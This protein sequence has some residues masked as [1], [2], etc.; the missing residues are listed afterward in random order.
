MLV[1]QFTHNDRT[2]EIHT[3][4]DAVNPRKDFDH[5]G[6]I[7]YNSSRYVLGDEEADTEEIEEITKSNAIW[8]PV[9]AYIH[10]GV[11][12]NTT[13][14]HCPWDSGQCGIIYV[15]REDALREYGRKR[16]SKKLVEQVENLLRSEI[17]EFDMYLRG[18]VYGYEIKDKEDSCWGSCW[19][20][21]GLDYCKEQ[22]K[23][24]NATLS[25]AV[26]ARMLNTK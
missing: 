5:L 23:A 14:F 13:G 16:M 6:K 1:E 22:A 17:E 20:F 11:T 10:S 25:L 7:L 9:Y 26:T 18:E 3:D 2:I 21:Y 24:A 12:I 15:T 4:E 19:G 8:L